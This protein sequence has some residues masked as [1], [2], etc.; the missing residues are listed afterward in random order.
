MACC[1]LD[2]PESA[3]YQLPY[4]YAL[5]TDNNN[6]VCLPC[7]YLKV[8]YVHYQIFAQQSPPHST[9]NQTS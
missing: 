1:L 6:S 5:C 3:L 2:Q 7:R 4:D 8:Q 9:S